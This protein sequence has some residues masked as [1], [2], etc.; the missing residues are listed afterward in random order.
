MEHEFFSELFL[1]VFFGNFFIKYCSVRTKKLHNNFLFFWWGVK[2]GYHSNFYLECNTERGFKNQLYIELGYLPVLLASSGSQWSKSRNKEMKT[3][4]GDHVDGQLPQISIKLTR[5]TQTSGH[6]C[7]SN[8][9][10]TFLENIKKITSSNVGLEPT[11]L[12][13]R[14]SCSTEWASRA[15]Q[16]ENW[17]RKNKLK[18]SNVVNMLFHY[19]I[20]HPRTKLKR[21]KF[22]LAG[23]LKI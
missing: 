15:G 13:L 6:T 18:I 8:I 3:R 22:S 17:R 11:T 9:W 1:K 7:K 19:L 4:E 2:I 5:E 14:V 21:K 16:L 10:I 12:G 20:R 23:M